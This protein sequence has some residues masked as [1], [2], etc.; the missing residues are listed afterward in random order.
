MG[1]RTVH[2]CISC[3]KKNGSVCSELYTDSECTLI[4]GQTPADRLPQEKKDSQS[5]QTVK[6]QTRPSEEREDGRRKRK[7]S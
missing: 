3:L 1:S 6:R 5:T 4:E 2:I 7:E